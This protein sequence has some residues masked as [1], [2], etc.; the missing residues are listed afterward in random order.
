MNGANVQIAV[1]PHGVVVKL[2]QNLDTDM[3]EPRRSHGVALAVPEKEAR[4]IAD[5][6]NVRGT[7]NRIAVQDMTALVM[8]TKLYCTPLYRL[9]PVI[10]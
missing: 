2:K 5:T 1:E 9:F 10:V 7:E 6:L 8:T 4:K 3:V